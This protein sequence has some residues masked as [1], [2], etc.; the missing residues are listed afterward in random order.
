[1]T[2]PRHMSPGPQDRLRLCFRY[3]QD[4]SNSGFIPS[5][6]NTVSG[7][8]DASWL[9]WPAVTSTGFGVPRCLICIQMNALNLSPGVYKDT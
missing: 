3:S 2:A 9:P 7:C 5:R 1:M 8:Q 6:W 4:H